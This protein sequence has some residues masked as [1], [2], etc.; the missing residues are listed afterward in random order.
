MY[1]DMTATPALKPNPTT[2]SILEVKLARNAIPSESIARVRAPEIPM[3]AND[4][5]LREDK[6]RL[7]PS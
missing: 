5:A 3:M 6:S 4:N 7:L 1:E 2:A